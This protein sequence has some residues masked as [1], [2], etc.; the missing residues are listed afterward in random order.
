M[1]YSLPGN[2]NCPAADPFATSME[3]FAAGQV[4]VS[5]PSPDLG[6]Q[7]PAAEYNPFDGYVLSSRASTMMVSIEFCLLSIVAG[8]AVIC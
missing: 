5:F 7:E 8:L 4:P 6:A 1:C 2:I 3:S